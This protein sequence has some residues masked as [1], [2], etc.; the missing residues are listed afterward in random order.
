M[1][2]R[3]SVKAIINQAGMNAWTHYQQFGSN[4]GV[5]PSNAFSAVQPSPMATALAAR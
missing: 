2:I 4:E 1:C 5:N 3:D